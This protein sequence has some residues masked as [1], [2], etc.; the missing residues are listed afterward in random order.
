VCPVKIDIHEQI[1]GWREVM[2]EK[3]QIQTVKKQAMRVADKVLSNPRL[4]QIAT[5]V[6]STALD[7]LPHFA[8]YNRLNAWGKHRDVPK[9]APETFHDW[10]KNHRLKAGEVIG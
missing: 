8:I 6:V 9:A 1:Y 3:G 4:Y 5:T 7:A 2:D 10:Y